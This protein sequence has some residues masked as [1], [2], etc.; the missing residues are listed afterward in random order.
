MKVVVDTM[1]WVS[2]CTLK[3]GYRYRLLNRARRLRVRLYVSE[4]ILDELVTTLTEDLGRTRRYAFLARRAVLRMASLVALPPTTRKYVPG[5]PDDD[6]IVQTALTAKADFLVTAD[7]A[8]L[9]V[10]K[11]QDVEIITGSQFEHK[12]EQPRR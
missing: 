8:I 6:P 5:D 3:G 9:A 4:Y 2:Y 11:V 10:A 12:L 1:F 7:H